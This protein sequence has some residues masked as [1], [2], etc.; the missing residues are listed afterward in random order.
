MAQLMEHYALPKGLVG[1]AFKAD[2]NLCVGSAALLVESILRESGHD[3]FKY[4]PLVEGKV[5]DLTT[6]EPHVFLL[7]AKHSQF[8]DLR[9]SRGSVLLDPW[10]FVKFAGED[11]TIVPIG[12]GP[13]SGWGM[14]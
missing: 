11:V 9:L 14:A 10:R 4:D 13:S 3:V 12:R 1:Y 8:E 6:L 5:R 7:G 2:T